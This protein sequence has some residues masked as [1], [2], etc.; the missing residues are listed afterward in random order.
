MSVSAL[1]SAV[2]DL[3]ADTFFDEGFV[4]AFGRLCV[5]DDTSEIVTKLVPFLRLKPGHRVL[6][7][8]CGFGRHAME[9]A[10]RGMHVTGLDSS[11]PLIN[12]ARQRITGN[13]SVK[14]VH[15]DMRS[16]PLGPY[17]AVINLWTSF[18][19]FST[20]EEDSRALQAWYKCLAP[21]GTLL[22]ELTDL[23]RAQFFNRRGSETV[24]TKVHT[25]NGVTEE[26]IF[27]WGLNRAYNR[28]SCGDWTRCCTTRIYSREEL[29][30]MLSAA[31]FSHIFCFGSFAGDAKKQGDRLIIVANK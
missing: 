20:A 10:S 8:P 11:F 16:P 14:Y 1:P 12:M 24:S 30:Q 27:D 7:V 18:G 31:G 28:Y 15:G 5:F 21:H 6:D 3:W 13:P 29:Q 26:A 23:E 17:D 25:E 19:Y 4:Q 22:M 9:L 2:S